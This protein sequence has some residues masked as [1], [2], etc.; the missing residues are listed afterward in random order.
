[1]LKVQAVGDHNAIVFENGP[2]VALMFI[3]KSSRLPD[4]FRTVTIETTKEGTAVREV[5]DPVTGNGLFFENGSLPVYQVLGHDPG[6]YAAMCTACPYDIVTAFT[7]NGDR[8]LI[9][10]KETGNYLLRQ[11]HAVCGITPAWNVTMF[12]VA[13]NHVLEEPHDSHYMIK[14]FEAHSFSETI[15]PKPTD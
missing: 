14:L 6:W 10:K 2:H 7:K 15:R 5:I 12:N 9:L 8:F 4:P 11:L 1:M 13:W 3:N